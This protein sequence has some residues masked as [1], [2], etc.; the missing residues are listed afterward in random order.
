VAEVDWKS[1]CTGRKSEIA[2][3][4]RFLGAKF[5]ALKANAVKG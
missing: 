5:G 4:F 3:R 1:V 2:D